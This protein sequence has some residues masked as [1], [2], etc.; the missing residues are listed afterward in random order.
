MVLP[1]RMILFQVLFILVA[2][3]TESMVLHGRLKLQR[4]NS[5]QYAA[6]LNLFST[7][8]GWLIFYILQGVFSTW[9]SG[10]LNQ[11]VMSYILFGQFFSWDWLQGMN[12]LLVIVALLTFFGTFLVEWNGLV[13][14]EYFTGLRQTLRP[15]PPPSND[16]L[17]R[18]T[19][20]T[21]APHQQL[22]IPNKGY[23]ILVANACSYSVILLILL[24]RNLSPIR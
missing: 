9:F 2:I 22:P 10:I 6:C 1:L 21:P 24:V 17:N 15:L 20:Y 11:Q 13:L 18:Y 8:I 12:T 3:A 7:A 5:V 14:L 4:K 19:A 23:A 16:T